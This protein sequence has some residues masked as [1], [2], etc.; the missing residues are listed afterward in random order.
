ML[1][2][3]AINHPAFIRKLSETTLAVIKKAKASNGALTDIPPSVKF[4]TRKG[5]VR[6]TRLSYGRFTVTYFSDDHGHHDITETIRKY[7]RF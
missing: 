5:I 2:R 6:V 3:T 4:K 7:A 1:N